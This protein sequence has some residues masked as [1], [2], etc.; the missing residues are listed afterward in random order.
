MALPLVLS[1]PLNPDITSVSIGTVNK[2]NPILPYIYVRPIHS[3]APHYEEDLSFQACAPQASPVHDPPL[4]FSKD[5]TTGNVAWCAEVYPSQNDHVAALDQLATPT[6]PLSWSNTYVGHVR[7]YTSHVAK[8]SASA[9]C[10]ATIPSSIP[11]NDSL[12]RPQYPLLSAGQ[13]ANGACAAAS[14]STVPNALA[15]HPADSVIDAKS[16]FPPGCTTDATSATSCLKDE[17]KIQMCSNNTCDRTA[18]ISGGLGWQQFPLLAS[19]G[20]VEQAISS[21]TTYGCVMTYDGGGPKT[22]KLT[23]TTG[24]CGANVN[25]ISGFGTNGN[26]NPAQLTNSAHLEPDAPCLIPTY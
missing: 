5:F 22:G 21:D 11:P 4:H 19:A 3:W 12:N 16:H 17:T 14:S 18:I 2:N 15:R 26:Q 24:C 13:L 20:Q 6:A 9:D 8:N 25:M 1:N 7:P 23:P 10:V